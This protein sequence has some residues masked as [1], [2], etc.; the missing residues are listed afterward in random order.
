MSFFE[1]E[2]NKCTQAFPEKKMIGRAMYI[3]LGEENRL[4]IEFQDS[5]VQGRYDG[6]EMTA[7]GKNHGTIDQCSLSF[8]DL[9]GT[10]EVDG[11][12][13][14]PYACEYQGKVQ[15]YSYVPMSCEMKQEENKITDYAELFQEQEQSMAMQQF[16]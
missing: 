3:P 1:T 5:Q 15:W 4:K 7:I 9:W 14:S 2:L 12:Q 11:E 6:L 10:Q 13:I 8:S 16:M